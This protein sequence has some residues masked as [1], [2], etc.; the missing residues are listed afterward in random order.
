[1]KA[2]HWSAYKPGDWSDNP[3]ASR[4]AAVEQLLH[5]QDNDDAWEIGDALGRLDPQTI[6]VRGY[7]ETRE[8]LPEG[9]Q[10]DGYEPGQPY[11]VPTGETAKVRVSVAMEILP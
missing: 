9:E 11:F 3:L 7:V 8:P 1:M 5:D 4:L 10:F 6:T 2:T